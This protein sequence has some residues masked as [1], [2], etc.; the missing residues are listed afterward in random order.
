[1]AVL[2]R[3]FLVLLL[4]VVLVGSS[5]PCTDGDESGSC[6]A[7]QG[8]AHKASSD[9]EGQKL[10]EEVPEELP[11]GSFPEDDAEVPPTE[12]ANVLSEE[13]AGLNDEGDEDPSDED[14]KMP[15][16]NDDLY[17]PD[18]YTSYD[19]S[20][21]EE[22]EEEEFAKG[23][24]YVDESLFAPANYTDEYKTRAVR[25]V[26]G[27]YAETLKGLEPQ[28]FEE[29][30]TLLEQEA[31]AETTE[32]FF[33]RLDTNND[34]MLG[35]DEWS[36]GIAEEGAKQ[37][38]TSGAFRTADRDQNGKIGLAEFPALLENMVDV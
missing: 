30:L 22:Q 15:D 19:E 6:A 34:G 3:V 32:Q 8:N 7:S 21:T 35:F 1:M 25:Y 14:Q 24:G 38:D 27:H 36:E 20:K 16:E 31:E 26:L 10:T 17:A 11:A 18:P 33:A 4:P 13:E 23:G 28:S 12:G 29:K 2:T 5:E 9:E 37:I